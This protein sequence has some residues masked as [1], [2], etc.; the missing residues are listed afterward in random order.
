MRKVVTVLAVIMFVAVLSACS[1]TAVTCGEGTIIQ[2]G[3]CVA[4]TVKQD[5]NDPSTPNDS[6]VSCDDVTGELF[7]EVDFTALQSNFV[8]N[9]VGNEHTQSNFV[10]WGKADTIQLVELA[11]VQNGTL[12][13]EGML[14]DQL[15]PYYD[16]GLGYQFF[17]FETDVT[18]TVCSIIEG[19]DGQYATSELGIYYGHGTRDQVELT[20]NEQLVIQDFKPTLTTN[21]DRGQYVLF[22]G[23]IEGD[24]KVHYIKIVQ[25]D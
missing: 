12:V 19:P 25:N 5:E 10:I 9:E 23:N 14:G 18:Y 8:D 1:P 11:F 22:T 6:V 15:K 2:D 16:T 20:G 21:V 13:I 7:Y 3:Q 4:P 24:F 17:D